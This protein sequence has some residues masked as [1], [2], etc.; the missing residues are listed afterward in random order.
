MGRKLFF[1]TLSGL[2]FSPCFA[3]VFT[4]FNSLNGL[5]ND[6]VFQV[7]QDKDGFIWAA[8]SYG[9]NKLGPNGVK[10]YYKNDGLYS[11]NILSLD[12]DDRGVLWVG[13]A[14]GLCRM[15]KNQVV[16]VYPG[17]LIFRPIEL[18]VEKDFIYW[19]NQSGTLFSLN[20]K[21]EEVTSFFNF[22]PVLNIPDGCVR[23][24][25]RDGDNQV[26]VATYNGLYKMRGDQM[27]PWKVEGLPDSA[28]YKVFKDSK[29]HFWV[30]SGNHIYQ[31]QQNKVVSM[32][33]TPGSAR[34]PI[35][36]IYVDTYGKLWYSGMNEQAY[37]LM[38]YNSML[39]NMNVVLNNNSVVN[40][41]FCDGNGDI[42]LSTF[43]G[44]LFFIKNRPYQY[45]NS[46]NGLAT[47]YTTDVISANRYLYIGTNTCFHYY[48]QTTGLIHQIHMNL[49]GGTEYIRNVDRF[50][51]N[52]LVSFASQA[53][54]SQ[55][56]F[57][58]RP[59][60]SNDSIYFFN[61]RYVFG[62]EKRRLAIVDHYDNC[63][64]VYRYEEG[65]FKLYRRFNMDNFLGNNCHVNKIVELN[66]SYYV[67]TIKGLF[68]CNKNFTGGETLIK[69]QSVSDIILYK[70]KVLIAGELGIQI[71]HPDGVRGYSFRGFDNDF[72][73]AVKFCVD[74]TNRLWVSTEKGI[75]LFDNGKISHLG[76]SD[77]LPSI[78]ITNFEYEAE[79]NIMWLSS[80]NG[81]ISIYLNQ[82]N[83]YVDKQ[84][85]FIIE[86]LV[87]GD[88]TYSYLAPLPK[89]LQEREIQIKTAFFNYQAPH[90]FYLRYKMDNS[91]WYYINS[92]TLNIS[93]VKYGNHT[94]VL[95]ASEYGYT[96]SEP[97]LYSFYISPYWYEQWW[98]KLGAVVVILLVIVAIIYLVVRRNNKKADKKI[99]FEKKVIDLKLQALNAA[100]NSHFVFNV[101]NAI[102]Y[103]VS[104]NQQIKAS[105]FIADFA[106]FMRIIIDNSN[107][108]I[109]PV[110]EEIR[111]IHLYLGLEMMRFEDRLTY[112]IYVDPTI[113]QSEIMLPNM[114]IQPFVENS[115]LHGILTTK[116]KGIIEIKILDEA[117]HIHI[118]IKDNG[119]GIDAAR[120]KKKI[121]SR[122]S[123]GLKNVLQRLELFSGKKDYNYSIADLSTRGETGTLVDIRLPKIS[124]SD[125]K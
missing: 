123:I 4:N 67:C 38:L 93:H 66:G 33:G 52:F 100:I 97:I 120:L 117:S 69:N 53:L 90:H 111:R 105:K 110:E 88:T 34:Y 27:L 51:K 42:W 60:G 26:V 21:T 16:K 45:F 80:Y 13:T 47:S 62:D 23:S 39:Y 46:N 56:Y 9:L 30:S 114:M 11:S 49:H 121:F 112:S 98:V 7:V 61:S 106:K 102:Q 63:L 125:I 115:I 83:R 41:Y 82:M 48:D 59:E 40:S 70:G 74:N 37:S 36:Q 28:F 31:I 92:N 104:A 73:L 2:F 29:N 99:E 58:K 68:R 25:A 108:T 57:V 89:T 12:M 10:K 22:S 113:N 75:Y 78:H 107:L 35:M 87:S 17:N 85:Q 8:T 18:L 119:I 109:I 79:K 32:V 5:S 64:T 15:E 95:Q 55:S 14:D 116:T 122:K 101:L 118:V 44:G 20:R 86:E 84:P 91:K 54:P 103:F 96:W 43:G 19:I 65:G 94:I 124:L 72:F 71:Y 24:L 76:P 6:N 1:L 77:G 3:F 50:G 81:I